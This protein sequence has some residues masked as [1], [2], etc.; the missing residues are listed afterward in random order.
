MEEQP[1]SPSAQ[2]DGNSFG[3]YRGR[4]L[5]LPCLLFVLLETGWRLWEQHAKWPQLLG[6]FNVAH[7][8]D[9]G[10]LEW[11]IFRAALYSYSLATLLSQW[12]HA[13]ARNSSVLEQL[14]LRDDNV[15]PPAPR[16]PG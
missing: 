5:K 2:R 11:L 16:K 13:R 14:A 9:F 8:S 6:G 15:W 10:S 7:V 1:E 12:A 4:W 3:L